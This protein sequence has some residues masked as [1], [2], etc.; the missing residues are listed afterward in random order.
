M[1]AA[2]TALLLVT[3]CSG[4]GQS[5]DA[6]GGDT[7]LSEPAP[8]ED[9]GAEAERDAALLGDEDAATGSDGSAQSTSVRQPAIIATATIELQS[10]DVSVARREVQKITD[11]FGGFVTTE[12]TTSDDGELAWSRVVLRVP[13]KDFETAISELQQ[14][15]K[16]LSTVRGSEDVTTQIIDTEARIR[17]QERALRRV[18][19]LLT[20]AER[21]ADV[22]AIEAELTRRQ[23]ELDSLKQQQAWLSD[24]TSFSTITVHLD[25][26]PEEKQEDE[27]E[28]GFLAGLR[29][30]WDA[31]S[32]AAVVV[33]TMFGVMVS[34]LP[35]LAGL[36]LV[37][38]WVRRR[39]TRER[40]TAS[41]SEPTVS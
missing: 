21:L 19:Q 24:Q 11:R 12:E 38:W 10:D 23:S 8:A 17:A 31:L 15:D 37:V 7:M 20:R 3:G 14:V 4:S 1:A 5:E 30:G 26:T 9:A 22:I 6:N 39:V 34:W 27:D 29:A 25:R 32:G 28:N 35:V 33:A 36:A 13:S 41:A 2:L 16:L 40:L 18:E